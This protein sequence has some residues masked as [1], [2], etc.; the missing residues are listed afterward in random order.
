M[1]KYKQKIHR[2]YLIRLPSVSWADTQTHIMNPKQHLFP[3]ELMY[4]LFVC[5]N[6]LQETF[7]RSV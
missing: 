4:M 2:V 3:A 6:I 5:K 7:E 1:K